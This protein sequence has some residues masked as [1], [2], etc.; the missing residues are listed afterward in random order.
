MKINLL[1]LALF[2]FSVNIM[3]QNSNATRVPEYLHQK[4][5]TANIQTFPFY[6]H[7][8]QVPVPF[9]LVPA[10]AIPGMI[11][12]SDY[13]TN[14]NM[15]QQII[16]KGDTVVAGL[17]YAD[18]I[19]AR[20][21]NGGNSVRIS[22]NYSFTG[23]NTWESTSR[24]DLTSVKSRWPDLF[25][26]NTPAGLTMGSTGRMWNGTLRAG[27][28]AVD[29][30]LGA[31]TSTVFYVP[32]TGQ[33]GNT[34]YFNDRINNDNIAGV[35][36]RNDTIYYQGFN[37]NTSVYGSRV[38][39]YRTANSN[40]VASYDVYSSGNGST[41]ALFYNF[42]NESIANGGEGNPVF[43]YQKST[44]NGATWSSPV[45]IL[46]NYLI[47]GDSAEAYWHQDAAFKPTTQ[48]PYL[49]FT[50]VPPSQFG[51]WNPGGGLL[52]SNRKGYNVCIWSPNL[53]GG[54][55]VRI[56]SYL[57]I[58]VLSDTNKFKSVTRIRTISAVSRFGFQVNSS[59][60]GHPSIGF[61]DDG[62][63][64]HV[65]FEVAR[66]DTSAEGFNY[67]DVYTTRST[68]GGSTWSNPQ[69]ISNTLN[70][71]EMYPSVAKTG[72]TSTGYRLVYHSTSVPGCQGFGP[73]GS[74]NGVESQI[75]A[76]VYLVYKST[77]IGITN[78]GT[79]IP[80]GYKLEQNY[81]NPFNPETSIRFNIPKTSNV[82]LKVYDITGKIVSVLANNENV[83]AGVK[84]VKFNASNFASG[85]YFY[86]LTAGE[87][88]ETKKMI[89]V[90]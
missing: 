68:D 3:A 60:V 70:E 76:P 39:V 63:V 15:L 46:N 88:T 43:R 37:T 25:F 30:V 71:D 41:L 56:A 82:T 36:Q 55:P 38:F 47:S 45:K 17:I 79:E 16:V 74:T 67:F 21:L 44:D 80:T 8:N 62:S 27:G 5:E 81:P 13:A 32:T 58:D 69:N 51:N 61:S 87:F 40:T 53:N 20:N 18:S 14:G 4:D 65:A 84:E 24:F 54:N 23:G 66:P 78:I 72:N 59:I 90:K 89:L 33:A 11:G 86:S 29:A 35:W 19:E 26:R 10:G 7:I 73:T 50:T 2:L 75:I 57:N 1:F 77:I 34:D 52:D 48:D 49:V 12:F 64:I 28:T 31:G 6:K 22:Y 83:T 42:V 85:I 9:M